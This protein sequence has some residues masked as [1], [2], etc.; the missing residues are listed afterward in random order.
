[1][2]VATVGVSFGR[3]SDVTAEA[4]SAV[5]LE[6]SLEKV[7]ELIHIG[8]RMRRVGLQSAMAGMG[9]SIV[10]M[11]AAVLGYL[12][13]IAGVIAQEIIDVIAVANALRVAVSRGPLSDL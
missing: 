3:S 11:I 7:D 9:M 1:M 12:P 6:S 2:L 8:R 5:I 10:G 13:P 4:A